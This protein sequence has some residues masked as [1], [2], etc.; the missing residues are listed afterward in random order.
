MVTEVFEDLVVSQLGHNISSTRLSDNK[1][2]SY[3]KGER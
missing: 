3:I 1:D 2:E